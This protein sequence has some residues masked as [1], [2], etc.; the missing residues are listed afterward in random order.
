MANINE[1]RK[2]L[3]AHA[4]MSLKELNVL[5]KGL[6][7]QHHP[8]RFQDEQQRVEAEEMSQRIIAAYKLLESMHPETHAIRK[9]ELE[10]AMAS[11]VSDWLYE[12]EVLTI[13]FVDG[14]AAE[15]R[16]LQDRGVL[17]WWS[18][19]DLKLAMFRPLASALVLL[20]RALFGADPW[21]RH[22][23]SALWWGLGVLAVAWVLRLLLPVATALLAT[24][25]YALDGA[26]T[27]PLSLR[28]RWARR[29]RSIV[30][31]V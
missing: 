4:A 28:S 19:P 23:H 29:M 26:H 9:R 12:R 6:M 25:L 5:Y 24:A 21:L 15:V 10:E 31:L 20:D 30:S 3:G 8:D 1:S 16:A 18:A 13:N 14:S 22:L 11:N 17:P 2:L 27:L 7:K